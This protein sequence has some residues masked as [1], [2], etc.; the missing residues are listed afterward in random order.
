MYPVP[1]AL[2]IRVIPR[3]FSEVILNQSKICTRG[4]LEVAEYKYDIAEDYWCTQCPGCQ[5]SMLS[6]GIFA[7]TYLKQIKNLYSE[8]FSTSLGANI[9]S[10]ITPDLIYY[11][12]LHV[13]FTMYVYILAFSRRWKVYPHSC[14]IKRDTRT[15]LKT[16][17]PPALP[18]I[19]FA[20]LS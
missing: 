8:G 4:V 20:R 1:R 10:P 16:H 2:T 15:E 13:L 3:S 6:P 9:T 12:K 11:F 19:L 7:K 17:L 14:Q 5:P 18:N